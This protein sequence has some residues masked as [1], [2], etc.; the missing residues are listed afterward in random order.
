MKGI[1]KKCGQHHLFLFLNEK[2]R[3]H[4][5][6]SKERT[7]GSTL[8]RW[9]HFVTSKGERIPFG[10]AQFKPQPY[11]RISQQFSLSDS[12]AERAEFSVVV[13]A[14]HRETRT[15][16][17]TKE[18]PCTMGRASV[19]HTVLPCS[20]LWLQCLTQPWPPHFMGCY[21]KYL[22]LGSHW[23]RSFPPRNLLHGTQLAVS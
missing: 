11:L 19:P 22:L 23:L 8:Q 5:V 9:F 17:G 1:G 13:S 15:F 4:A 16:P 2:E 6:G 10:S 18:K 21:S 12:L 20:A 14:S 3:F 7:W